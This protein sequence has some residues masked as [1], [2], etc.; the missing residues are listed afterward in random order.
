[1]ARLNGIQHSLISSPSAF[2]VDL[3]KRLQ[4]ELNLVLTHEE[5]IWALKFRINW[6]VFGDKNTSFY[7]LSTIVRRKRNRISAMKNSVGDWLYDEREV[8]NYIRKSFM[9]LY[10]TSHSQASWNPELSTR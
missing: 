9:E 5:K 6:M 3:E 1:M 2:L 8:M 4:W 7:H 10:T